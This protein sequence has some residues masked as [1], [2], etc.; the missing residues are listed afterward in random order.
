LSPAEVL[1]G[2]PF[3]TRSA[4]HKSQQNLLDLPTDARLRKVQE[5]AAHHS[6]GMAELIS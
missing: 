6:R 5:L 4:V 3:E 2:K 1:A